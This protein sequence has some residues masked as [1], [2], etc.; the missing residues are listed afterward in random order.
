MNNKIPKEVEEAIKHNHTKTR[1]VHKK[2]T[3]G[4][5]C[6][7]GRS[8]AMV[9]VKRHTHWFY[10]CFR[11]KM[12]G[13]IPF[14]T[15]TPKQTLKLINANKTEQY[16]QKDSCIRLPDDFEQL[17]KTTGPSIAK[18]WLWK[19]GIGTNMWEKHNI[20]W[21]NSYQRLIFP[22][23][24]TIRLKANVSI[25]NQLVGWL[26]RDVSFINYN[27]KTLYKAPKYLLKTEPDQKRK[28]F[29][30][31]GGRKADTLI[32]VEDILSAIK[33]FNSVENVSVL[34]LL[35]SSVDASYI[36][37]HFKH[38]LLKIWLDHDKRTESVMQVVRLS[39]LG[40]SVRHIFSMKDPKEHTNESINAKIR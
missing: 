12:H 30:L 36:L 13:E 21:S 11:C 19:Y 9:V 35:N 32:I 33:I 38:C 39:Q 14:E 27:D 29:K 22:I 26:A 2:Q 31:D 15:N 17:S 37:K 40:F 4:E 28:F 1:I 23:K 34:A 20:G 3:N 24:D 16:K 8:P 18:T 7:V 10:Y 6:S 5:N 25:L